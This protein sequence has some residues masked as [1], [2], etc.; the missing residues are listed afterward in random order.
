M[1]LVEQTTVPGTVLPVAQFKDHLRLGTGFA[2]D[3]VQD[4]V[5]ETCLRAAMAAIEAQTG[6]ILLSRSFTW[7]LSAWRDLATQALPVAP[8]N[9]ITRLSITDR[10]GGEEVIATN[11]YVLE[12]DTHRPR[13]VSTGLCLPAIPVGGQVV[14]EFEAG[15]GAA[16]SDMPAD[17]AQAVMMLAASYYEDRVGDV[18]SG[19]ANL[20]SAVAALIQRYRTVR[21]FGGGGAR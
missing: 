1:M 7:T 18:Q 3:G 14:I 13:L 21:L 9:Q 12:R 10:L 11:R 20:P 19:H 2:D 17:L 4:P 5:L 8:V 6:K 16:W 15:F